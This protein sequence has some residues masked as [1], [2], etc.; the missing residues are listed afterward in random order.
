MTEIEYWTIP[1]ADQLPL[2]EEDDGRC[3]Q[4]DS[5]A[6]DTVREAID[7]SD[8]LACVRD[9]RL[10]LRGGIRY[11][12]NDGATAVFAYFWNRH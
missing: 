8:A 1:G 5:P 10:E 12:G 3:D 9:P 7:L 4:I 6:C 2:Y 11:K